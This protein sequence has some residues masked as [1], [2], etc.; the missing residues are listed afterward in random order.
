MKKTSILISMLLV[1]WV[2][3]LSACTN[4]TKES[5]Y[6]VDQSDMVKTHTLISTNTWTLTEAEKA[7]LIKMREEEK[8][9]RDVYFMLWEKRGNQSFKNIAQSEQTH[10][11]AIKDLLVMYN[12]DDPVKNNDTWVFTSKDMGL[13]YVQLLTKGNQSLE[14]ALAVWA[15]IEDLDIKDLNELIKDTTNENIIAVY[16]NLNKWSRN[17]MRAFVKNI[18]KNNGTY[19]PQY[20]SIDEYNTIISAS[21]E[22]SMGR[23]RNQK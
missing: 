6:I 7:G 19:T 20:I 2:A 8:L 11:D 10:T 16:E 23:G 12:I 4:A 22:T 17:H 13:L 18:S 15:T 1:I 9:A 14:D 5:E 3:G 21:Q